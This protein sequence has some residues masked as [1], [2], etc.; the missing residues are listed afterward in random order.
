[1]GCLLET[2]P[3]P[4]K[5]GL[6]DAIAADEHRDLAGRG[7]ER[8]GGE[9]GAVTIAHPDGIDLEPDHGTA[10]ATI[11]SAAAATPAAIPTAPATGI[12]RFGSKTTRFRR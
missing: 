12:P 2:D 7:A 10:K 4:E 9:N 8:C 1:M 3:Y 5:G 11:N 6:A